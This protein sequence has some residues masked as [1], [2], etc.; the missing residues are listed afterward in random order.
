MGS[1]VASS[2]LDKAGQ[3]LLDVAGVRWTRSEL[4]G[5]LN[6]GQTEIAVAKPTSASRIVSHKLTAGS[7]QTTPPDGWML[8][9]VFR[10]RGTDGV[11]DG[12]A[13]RI[14]SRDLL[15][16]FS[17]NWHG[18][19][20]KNE[21]KNYVFNAQDPTTFYV[22]PPSTGNNYVE[23]SY[24]FRPVDLTSESQ[25]IGIDDVYRTMLL[26][27]IMFRACTKDAE[28]APGVALG[29][30]YYGLFKSMVE[31]KDQSE[32]QNNPN[33]DMTPMNP[34]SKGTAN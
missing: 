6:D 22:S 18:A 24:A 9:D 25:P 17:P 26:N 21:A 32:L 14:V 29:Q 23:I 34:A 28:Y 11:T 16:N 31:T 2:I 7:R 13:I 27:Y 19:T 30:M 8:L 3:L 10:N 12:P 33:L 1:V 4:L 5:W 20:R 15:D